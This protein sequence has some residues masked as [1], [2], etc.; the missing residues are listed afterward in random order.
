MQRK[1]EAAPSGRV[2]LP[3]AVPTFMDQ[4]RASSAKAYG[5]LE[6]TGADGMGVPGGLGAPFLAPAADSEGDV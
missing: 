3:R 2:G 5:G 1:V 4:L 6:A